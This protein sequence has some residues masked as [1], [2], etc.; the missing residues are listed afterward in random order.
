MKKL[1]LSLF[2]TLVI[3]VTVGIQFILLFF[4]LPVFLIVIGFRF[5]LALLIPIIFYIL[6]NDFTPLSDSLRDF[7]FKGLISG[8]LVS[9]FS[10]VIVLGFLLLTKNIGY[11]EPDL[12]Y[13]LGLSSIADY[14]IYL[15]WNI[16]EIYVF[17]SLIRKLFENNKFNYIYI[18]ATMFFII[19]PE[20]IKI[21]LDGFNYIST[22]EFC[23]SI[24]IISTLIYKLS[25]TDS[26]AILLFT[27]FWLGLLVFG[28]ELPTLV[29]LF[30]GSNYS[31]WDGFFLL[32][33]NYESYAFVTYLFIVSIILIIKPIE[34]KI[35]S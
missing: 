18:F 7:S 22:I 8:I 2:T 23:L 34:R 28:T 26:I 3:L 19:A 31:S 10:I 24:L 4:E 12:F 21:Q 14:P 35:Q 13:E 16:L 11:K 6:R 20:H 30:F 9:L 5:H 32:N 33:K 29:R 15:I 27:I 17:V 25:S 1:P